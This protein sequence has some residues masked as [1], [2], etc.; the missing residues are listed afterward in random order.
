MGL[1]EIISDLKKRLGFAEAKLAYPYRNMVFK[2]GGV[3]G[4]AYMGALEEL[5]NLGVTE[6]VER[7]AGTSAGAIT[8][9]L[10]S[11]RL[12]ISQTIDVFNTLDL[13][14]VPQKS[15]HSS[16][17]GKIVNL[18]N[19]GSYKRLFEKYGWYSSEY[20]Y[21]WISQTIAEQCNENERA[22]FNDFAQLGFRDLYIVAS[23]ISRHRPEVFSMKTTPDV[24]VADAVRLS[25]SIP[26]YFEALRFDGSEFGN[27]DYYVDGGLYDNY[28]LELFDDKSY[29]SDP[30]QFKDG[31]NFESLG[32][33][34]S[35][36]K[37]KYDDV[38]DYPKNLWEFV[39][40]TGRN[41][42]D[43]HQLAGLEKNVMD[44]KRTITISDC[45]VSSVDFDIHPDSEIYQQLY[46]SGRQ[47]VQE[48]F[49]S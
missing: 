43:S 48:Y 31:I 4:I 32:L 39:A 5:D 21:Q 23:N 44:E 36:E 7:V 3:R 24:S 40:L 45:G 16:R 33:F 26:L 28:P 9:T 8:A 20:F 1:L 6:G 25:M 19:P 34:L 10:L 12:T 30:G 13:S 2:G 46:D 35:P 11:F 18:A 17:G 41:F 15:A 47:A 27:G 29:V 42:Y 38:A 22:T 14:Q 49:K 37:T